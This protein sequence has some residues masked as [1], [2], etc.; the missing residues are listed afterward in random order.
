MGIIEFFIICIIIVI[1][2]WLANYAL[3]H[4][5]PGHP[6]IINNIIWFVV[7]IIIL[8]TL[9]NAMGLMNYDPRIPRLK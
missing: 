1:L 6:S 7:V 8:I 4:L 5:A 9:A 3:D 2:G